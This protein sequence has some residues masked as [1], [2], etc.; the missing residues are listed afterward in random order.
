MQARWVLAVLLV[1][2]TSLLGWLIMWVA[3]LSSIPF[4]RWAAARGGP[5]AARPR[6]ISLRESNVPPSG[7]APAADLALAPWRWSCAHASSCS[8]FVYGSPLKRAQKEQA[9]REDTEA[10]AAGEQVEEASKDIT[11]PA[12]AADAAAS[13]PQ[14]P[15][16][17]SAFCEHPL[18]KS[19]N[20]CFADAVSA[21]E[22]D[23][24]MEPYSSFDKDV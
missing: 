18:E 10:A 11:D 19:D 22:S 20:S 1:M 21:P 8:D 12:I 24:E 3:V 2:G 4:F 9:D 17:G 13:V 23:E 6:A 15:A 16:E 5:C 14:S 7:P